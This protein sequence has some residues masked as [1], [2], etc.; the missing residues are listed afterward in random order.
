MT[1]TAHQQRSHSNG[2]ATNHDL[3]RCAQ[4]GEQNQYCHGHTPIIPNPSLDLPPAQP[5]L[6]V[7]QPVQAH[8]VARVNLNRVQATVLAARIL[9]ALK[10]N[11]DA[12]AV[13]PPYNYG[14][15]IASIVAE[16]LRIDPAVTAE[17]LGV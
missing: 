5:R 1:T 6:P 15:E 8:S 12:A 11:E 7:Q 3:R 9:D 16:G 17:G 14:R 10:D 2:S 4:C 13:L